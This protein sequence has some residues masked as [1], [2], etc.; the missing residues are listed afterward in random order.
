[1]KLLAGV[2]FTLLWC[3][4]LKSQDVIM[5][6]FYWNTHPG[7]VTNTTT[8]GIW[9]DTLTLVAP[10]LAAAGFQT[11]WTPPPTKG[12]AG[13]WDMG[14]GTYDYFDLGEFNS[15]GTTR[16]R[17][18]S[19][20][21]LDAMIDA[22]N[23]NNINVMADVV[24]NHRGGADAQ[25]HVPGRRQFRLQRVSR[26][27]AAYAQRPTRHFHPNF[28]H[29]DQNPDYHNPL[30]FEDICYFNEGD[31]FPPTNTNGSPGSWFFGAPGITQIGTMGDSLIMWGRWLMNEVGF[32]EIRLDAVKHIDPWFIKKFLIESKNEI[33]SPIAVG[34]FFEYGLNNLVNYLN[35]VEDP[36]NSGGVKNAKISMFDFPLR[37]ALKSVLNNGS[38]SSDLYNTLGN[39]GL[40]WG[41]SMDGFDV[42]T[43]LDSH[44]TDRTGY[45][46]DSDGCDIPYGGAC[47]E[48]HTENDHNPIFS[49]KE[50]MG[51]PIPDGRRRPPHGILE[52]LVLVRLVKKH[53]MAN[54]FA[55]SHRH[56]NFQ[57]HPANERLMVHLSAF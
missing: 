20:A 26:R 39:A 44:D 51:Y 48:L 17:H 54:G 23:A 30:F 19:R 31:A 24:L 38:G 11:V 52:R 29:P 35:A 55:P 2:I 18:G 37:G 16:T 42:V 49:D 53:Q 3:A 6:G 45:I 10:Q 28:F 4:P 32:D 7:D 21:E 57:P 1:M 34:E 13:I 5:Q 9:W 12:F 47:L 36:A 43:W 15:K 25:A 22:L 50:D 41:T 46:G 14:Y 56:R 33:T 8:G 40:V 27:P